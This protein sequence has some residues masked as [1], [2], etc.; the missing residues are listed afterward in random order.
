MA[1]PVDAKAYY[2]YL[3]AADKKPTK[4]LDALLRGIAKHISEDVGDKDEKTLIP[5]K[6][7][8]FYKAPTSHD[9]DPPSIPALTT[10]GFVRWQSIEILL[11]PEEHVPFIQTAVREWA[12]KNPDTGETFPVELPKEAFPLKCDADI[13][14]WHSACA[15]RL[16]QRATPDDDDDKSV[17][18]ELPPR[19]R[20]RVEEGYTHSY[21]KTYILFSRTW[22]W[23]PA[24]T[25]N[26]LPLADPSSAP[27]S[28]RLLHP[29]MCDGIVTHDRN[30]K[31][32]S[33]LMPPPRTIAPGVLNIQPTRGHLD[34]AHIP[35]HLTRRVREMG[36]VQYA[37]RPLP[38]PQ[39]P[40]LLIQDFGEGEKERRR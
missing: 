10:R 28:G 24:R 35:I 38:H 27:I 25:S 14:K 40:Y 5:S 37:S 18:P 17:R 7:A 34:G 26:N 21:V 23:S 13:E 33:R 16:R 12:I 11:G 3:F 1:Q 30:A 4:V 9:F 29:I 22:Y 15:A 36:R 31:L 39:S 19:P 8:S 20:V 32:A 2:G 6:L